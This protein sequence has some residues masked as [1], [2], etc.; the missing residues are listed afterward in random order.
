MIK[1]AFN[2]E[3]TNLI[4]LIDQVVREKILGGIV[5]YYKGTLKHTSTGATTEGYEVQ[6]MAFESKWEEIPEATATVGLKN[7][8]KTATP[9]TTTVE[10]TPD[11]GYSGL[12]KVTVAAVTAAIDTNIVAE[13]IKKDV[14]I[15]GVTGTYEGSEE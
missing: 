5:E 9:A 4:F 2:K 3:N 1:L 15:L 8:T 13:N 11:T 12:S 7:Q 10:V 6:V 14:V